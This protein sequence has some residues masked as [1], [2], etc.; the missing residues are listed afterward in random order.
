MYGKGIYS[1]ELNQE[2]E[3]FVDCSKIKELE[4]ECPE[5]S[6]MGFSDDLNDLKI[7]VKRVE[8]SIYKCNYIPEKP[9]M[10]IRF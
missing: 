4:E 7:N 9:G 6:F 2:A 8:E 1:A 3:F 5:I 10:A